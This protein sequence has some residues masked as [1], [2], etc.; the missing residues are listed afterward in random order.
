MKF[1]IACLVGLFLIFLQASPAW[2]GGAL[3]GAVSVGHSG[4]LS[5][6]AGALVLGFARDLPLSARLAMGYAGGSAG[7]PYAARRIFIND[8]TNGDPQKSARTWQYRF[9][10]MVPFFRTGPQ[11]V[12][13]FAGPRYCRYR[14]NF[15]YVGGNENFDVTSNAWGA[16]VGLETW[17]AVTGSADMIV[18]VGL[19]WFKDARLTGHDTAYLPEGDHVNP[20]EG[21][22][23]EDADEAIDQPQVAMLAMIGMRFRL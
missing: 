12:Q 3:H 23:Y 5:L 11:T 7:D 18:Q 8:N 14:A 22:D 4:G 20:R 21:Y 19:D 1:A 6:Q 13:L 2:A 10:L 17:L 9:D 15:N 16:G